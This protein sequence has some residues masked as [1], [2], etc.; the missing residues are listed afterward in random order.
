MRKEYTDHNLNPSK[1]LSSD[2]PKDECLDDY[3]FTKAINNPYISKR[4]R[5]MAV[6]DLFAM[7]DRDKLMVCIAARYE[8]AFCGGKLTVD[9][10]AKR[11]GPVLEELAGIT[12]RS[13][14]QYFVLGTRREDG[15]EVM[16]FNAPMVK[17]QFQ[18]MASLQGLTEADVLS[19]PE[20]LDLAAKPCLFDC[21]SF[22]YIPWR[23][24]LGMAVCAENIREVGAEEM[25]TQILWEMTEV[26]LTAAEVDAQ[27][28]H[29]EELLDASEFE[30]LNDVLLNKLH[31]PSAEEQVLAE[32]RMWAT[33]N[34]CV[35][36]LLLKYED[37]WNPQP[38][39]KSS[40][41]M[42]KIGKNFEGVEFSLR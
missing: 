40:L 10:A 17:E 30:T 5:I 9:A 4:M 12:P 35:Y 31:R 28:Q 27:C 33:T 2:E 29:L 20:L 34:L 32:K 38:V 16:A 18:A 37:W 6:T 26:G 1:D 14:G 3:D 41:T 22:T 19:S 36:N 23:E 42:E 15:V 7:C 13:D 11:F 25:A 8:S 21:F 39:F 24:V